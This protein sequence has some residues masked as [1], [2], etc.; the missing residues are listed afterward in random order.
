M[1]LGSK[2]LQSNRELN[3]AGTNNVLNLEVSKLGIETKL[4]NDSG[5]F[6]RGQLR[7]ILRLSTS[8]DHLAGGEDKCGGLWLSNSHDDSGESLWKVST[9]CQR[10]Y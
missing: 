7:V 4:L 1:M 6:S 3:V 10:C 2:T 9:D 5:I 8:H